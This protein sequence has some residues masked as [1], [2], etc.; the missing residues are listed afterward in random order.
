MRLKGKVALVTGCTRGIGRVIAESL[1]AEGADIIANGLEIRQDAAVVSAICGLG[2]DALAV[3]ADI[4]VASQVHKM[5]ETGLKHFK[6]IDILVNNAGIYPAAPLLDIEEHQWNRVLDVNLKGSFLMTQAVAKMAML[7]QKYGR[8]VNITS[9]DGKMPTTGITHYSAA[10]AGVISLTKS[11]ALELAPHGINT[12]AV[13]PGWV[14]SKTVLNGDRWKEAIK[15]IPCG[16][17]A[18]LSEIAHAVT[19]LVEDAS[20]YINGETIDVNG[21]LLMD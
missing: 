13:A 12:N 3:A 19:F 6:H 8:I 15:H 18:E 4:T 20:S 9:C 11:S 1:A 7:P 2:R 5:V 10:K 21:G 14:K 16:R 17:L